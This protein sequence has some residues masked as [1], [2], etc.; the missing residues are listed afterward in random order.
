VDRPGFA[1]FFA[2][3]TPYAEIEH[4]SMGSR[5]P[6]RREGTDLAALRAIP[7][8]FAWSQNRCNLPGWYGLGSGLAA[9]AEE[10]GGIET[11]RSMYRDWAHF[12]SVIENVQLSLSK[13]DLP[14]AQLYLRLGDDADAGR[15]IEEEYE[16]TV[17]LVLDVTQQEHLLERRVVLRRAIELRNA[18]VDALSFLQLRFLEE[19]RGE[20]EHTPERDAQLRRLVQLTVNGLAAGLQNTG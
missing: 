4:M 17:T 11:L 19:L 18:Y 20:S 9:I 16:R 15:L 3:V 10:P 12:T 7:W 13:A 5:P 2:M 8:V 14:T 6:R 1:E